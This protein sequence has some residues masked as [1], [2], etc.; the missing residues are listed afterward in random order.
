MTPRARENLSTVSGDKSG[1]KKSPLGNSPCF[2][3]A[4]LVCLIFRRHLNAL[5]LNEN[6]CELRK[7]LKPL[8]ES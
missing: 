6:I 7:S 3:L 8:E 1:E 5:I 2:R 4:S